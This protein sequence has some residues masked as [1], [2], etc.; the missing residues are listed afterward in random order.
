MNKALFIAA[1]I[2]LNGTNAWAN[3]LNIVVVGLF[4]DKAVVEIN[5]T[6]RLLQIGV[7]SPEGVTLI[8]ANSRGAKLEVAGTTKDY[9]LGSHVNATFTPPAEQA[10]VS[11]WPTNGM[12]KTAGS[13]NGYSVNFLVDTGASTIAF[14]TSVAERLDL[15][16][17]K[18][19]KTRASTASGVTEAYEIMLDEVQVG[20]IKLYDIRALVIEGMHPDYSL[21]GMSFLNQLNIER[22]DD[23]M[24]LRKKF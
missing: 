24:D 5:H 7:A 13:V 11:I 10:P 16:Y 12:Y 6:R 3:T 18:G 14:S 21:L 23:R 2:L 19:R 22:K 17:L 1:I 15:D 4:K 20:H 9:Q 8:S